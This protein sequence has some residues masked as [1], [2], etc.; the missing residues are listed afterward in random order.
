[1]V[2]SDPNLTYAIEL[3]ELF[4]HGDAYR[5][6]AACDAMAI[7]TVVSFGQRCFVN[8]QRQPG[9]THRHA[10]LAPGYPAA[11]RGGALMPTSAL[12]NVV[13]KE[14]GIPCMLTTHGRGSSSANLLD[15]G[16]ISLVRRGELR[17]RQR[18]IS[19]KRWPWAV[20]VSGCRSWRCA[21]C[22]VLS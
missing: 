7:A 16:R 20:L 2:T 10:H 5:F 1:V 11:W 9:S 19:A 8:P 13:A 21:R 3:A 4:L 12:W 17:H 22:S 15:A 6:G 14:L 18:P